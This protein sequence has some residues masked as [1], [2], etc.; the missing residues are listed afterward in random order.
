M[1]PWNDSV[2]AA[3]AING[4]LDVLQYLH[5]NGCPWN[6]LACELAALNG[7]LDVLKYLHENGC[8]CDHNVC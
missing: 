6:A 1:G 2:C 7:H 3:T 4:H 5:E 8:P